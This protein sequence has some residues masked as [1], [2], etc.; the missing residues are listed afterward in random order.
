MLRRIAVRSVTGPRTGHPKLIASL[1]YLDEMC[2]S[3][4]L[5]SETWLSDSPE[6]EEDLKDVEEGTGYSMLLK[7]KPKNRRGYSTGGIT[8]VSK[9]SKIK[10]KEVNLPW[11]KFKVVCGVGT[12]T[13]H[14]Q[15]VVV[16]SVYIPPQYS[17]EEN[18]K[19][20]DFIEDSL[21]RLKGQFQGPYIIV[22]GDFN[23]R[24]VEGALADIPD[25]KLVDSPA[26]HAGQ[27]L[28]K[29]FVNFKSQI[30]ESGVL[31][32]LENEAGICSDHAVI[33]AQA[34]LKRIESFKWIR[35][36][37]LRQ[38]RSSGN[39]W[40]ILIGKGVLRKI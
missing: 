33:Y 35:D 29:I 25:M 1:I 39:G 17:A 18:R 4:A 14:V 28:D 38:K 37:Q 26:T 36:I 32:P 30:H 20:L 34:R 24:D 10:F 31:N 12:L 19:C 13:Y 7:N 11:N 6:L 15:K 40:R 8:I 22:G 9:N 16:V 2:T 3:V 21:I 27:H 23:K 5:V